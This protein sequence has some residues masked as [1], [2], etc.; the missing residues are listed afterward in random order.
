MLDWSCLLIKTAT[1]P[2]CAV[3]HSQTQASLYCHY[4]T[5]LNPHSTAREWTLVHRLL[6]FQRYKVWCSQWNTASKFHK[7]PL[8]SHI[9]NSRK[10]LYTLI[11]IYSEYAHKWKPVWTLVRDHFVSKTSTIQATM[12]ILIWREKPC[13]RV[14]IYRKFYSIWTKHHQKHDFQNALETCV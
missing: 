8:K 6:F 5:T 11:S 12:H 10:C 3:V 13:I 7:I 2:S 9:Y 1:L 14:M 4:K